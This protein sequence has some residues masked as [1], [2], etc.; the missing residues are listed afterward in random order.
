MTVDISLIPMSELVEELQSRC[1]TFICAYETYEEIERTGDMKF[2]FGKGRWKDAVVL[3]DILHN[4]CLN[5]WSGE[6]Q[7]LQRINEEEN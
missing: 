1:A 5:S 4:D 3:A 6:L 7:T 2:W